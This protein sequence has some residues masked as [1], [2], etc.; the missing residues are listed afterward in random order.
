MKARLLFALL[1]LLAACG[2]SNSPPPQPADP[3]LQL[4]T[5]AGQLAIERERPEEA[6]AGYQAALARAQAR[7]DLGAIGD[8]GYNL[9]VAELQAGHPDQA[10]AVARATEQERTRRGA[11]PCPELILAEATALYRLG[12]LET[13]DARARDASAGTPSAT[14]AR[15][16]FLRG[17]IADDRND[18]AGLAA[19]SASLGQPKNPSLQADAAERSARLA[20][21][22]GDE[23][24]ARQQAAVAAALR[25][26]T[27]DFRG[28]DRALVLEA[29][30][31][32]R[33]GDVAGASDL[34][35]R[36]GRSALTQGDKPSARLWL[37]KAEAIATDANVRDAAAAL[38]SKMGPAA[39]P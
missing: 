12:D 15:A 33:A 35:F 27:L 19:A 14:T 32:E 16:Q 10:L 1:P 39:L 8:S 5:D 7:D 28:L 4:E 22:Q 2:N 29:E 24:S 31:A 34:Y 26:Q 9:A 6:V 17:L 20:L 3:T 18:A 30:A 13:A 37:G 23:A 25:Q 11:T 36:A 38:L 21:R